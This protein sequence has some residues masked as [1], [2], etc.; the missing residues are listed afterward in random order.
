M[1]LISRIVSVFTLD[2]VKQA[3]AERAAAVNS[4]LVK[5]RDGVSLSLIETSEILAKA[6]KK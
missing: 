3:E 1:T 6:S 4:V 5:L 2:A